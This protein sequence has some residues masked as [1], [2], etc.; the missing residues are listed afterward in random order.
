MELFQIYFT[1]SNA[2]FSQKSKTVRGSPHAAFAWS[3]S[4]KDSP[5]ERMIRTEQKYLRAK[6]KKGDR[7]ED[8]EYCL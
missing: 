8:E 6:K 1:V 3:K 2:L 7:V 5:I 4:Q